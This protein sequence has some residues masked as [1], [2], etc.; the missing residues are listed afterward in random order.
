MAFPRLQV[1][2]NTIIITPEFSF[3]FHFPSFTHWLLA[4]CRKLFLIP[5]PNTLS[6]IV[7]LDS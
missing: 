7:A 2:T 3:K 4:T 1:H 6:Y 5:I